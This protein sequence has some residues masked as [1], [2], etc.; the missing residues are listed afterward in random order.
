ME[1][2]RT[3]V[4]GRW[5]AR[6][7]WE[8]TLPWRDTL[9]TQSACS[10]TEHWGLWKGCYGP[11]HSKGQRGGLGREAARQGTDA[12]PGADGVLFGLS[13]HQRGSWSWVHMWFRAI[14]WALLGTG[15]ES[16]LMDQLLPRFACRW[17]SSTAAKLTGVDID[18]K[19][20]LM[21]QSMP[22]LS[23][24]SCHPLCPGIQ[25]KEQLQKAWFLFNFLLLKRREYMLTGSLHLSVTDL[26]LTLSCTF[27]LVVTLRGHA[28]LGWGERWEEC[29][30]P[31]VQCLDLA[32]LREVRA[33][34]LY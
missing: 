8:R 7:C 25:D 15:L 22:Q 24:P 5:R 18:E 20:R 23:Q 2:E 6:A 9:E 17:T 26:D 31:E 27:W 4:L 28:W 16:L 1:V 11:A 3:T 12:L 30:I 13:P 14:H 29:V 33:V 19:W 10:Y 34:S 32:Y 21:L